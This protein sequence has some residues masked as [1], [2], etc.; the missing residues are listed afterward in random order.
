[1]AKSRFTPN[2]IMAVVR[3]INAERRPKDVARKYG[4]SPTTLY[5]WRAKFA[6]K[7]KASGDRIRLLEIENRQLKSKFAELTLDYYS[8]R[9][10]LIKEATGDC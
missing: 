9:S 3:E 10:A 8:L 1:M 5:R 4:V 7:R 6:N 2:Q